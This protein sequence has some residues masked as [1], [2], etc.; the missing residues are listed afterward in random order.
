MAWLEGINDYKF[1]KIDIEYK[2][3]LKF[4]G[5]FS[6]NGIKTYNSFNNMFSI[7]IILDLETQAF[8]N[9]ISD[10]KLSHIFYFILKYGATPLVGMSF[11]IYLGKQYVVS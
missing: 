4:K 1:E 8:S 6:F 3:Y 11:L 10:I 2:I 7:L 9:K 5:K